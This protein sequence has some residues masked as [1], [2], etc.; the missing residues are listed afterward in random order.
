MAERNGTTRIDGPMRLGDERTGDEQLSGDVRDLRDGPIRTD[1]RSVDDAQDPRLPE[2]AYRDPRDGTIRTRNSSAGRDGT[3][4]DGTLPDGTILRGGRP[5]GGVHRNYG[6]G[7]VTFH[8]DHADQQR[9]LERGEDNLVRQA[10]EPDASFGHLP[11]GEPGRFDPDDA[12]RVD[13]GTGLSPTDQLARGAG[14]KV[15]VIYQSPTGEQT[16]T[17]ALAGKTVGDARRTN[18]VQKMGVTATST[19]TVDGQAVADTFVLTEGSVLNFSEP[20]A[21][22]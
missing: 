12:R 6:G 8:G 17:W 21:A 10:R 16:N 5:R 7:A 19:A 11:A 2:G 22:E 14:R 3:R 18:G 9:A 20:P 15:T 1:R 4:G 13:A